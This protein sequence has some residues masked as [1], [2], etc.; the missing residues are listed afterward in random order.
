MN[1]F[2]YILYSK[3]LDK[4]YIGYTQDN[5]EKRLLKHQTAFY[6][7]SFSKITNDWTVF[8]SIS[9]EC[10]S[11]ALAIEKHI[12]KMKSRIYMQNLKKYPEIS[13]KLKEKYSC[14]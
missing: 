10:A 2:C 14:T 11:Q 1:H 8:F 9:C 4:Y 7:N 12:K 5:L 13:E 3:T 6:N